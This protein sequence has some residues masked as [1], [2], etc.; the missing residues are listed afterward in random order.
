[1]NKRNKIR[2]AVLACCLS[3]LTACKDERR[4]VDKDKV[5]K[6]GVAGRFYC[7]PKGYL[8]IGNVP[9]QG[10]LGVNMMYPDFDYVRERPIDLHKRGEWNRNMRLYIDTNHDDLANHQ[11]VSKIIEREE[12]NNRIGDAYDLEHWQ[13]W[14][15]DFGDYYFHKVDGQYQNYI[16]C[17]A[18]ILENDQSLCQ[19]YVRTDRLR[20][21]LTYHKDYLPK[22]Q[23][24]QNRFMQFLD[25]HRCHP[26]MVP[27]HTLKHQST[28]KGE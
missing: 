25:D 15:S 19:H 10:G 4:E 9:N 12:I 20:I 3:L 21:E 5:Y 6:T 16:H 17:S 2:I 8:S 27:T 11:A 13:R 22:W 7:V 1:M 26:D 24:L 23:E 14:H 28:Q 18:I